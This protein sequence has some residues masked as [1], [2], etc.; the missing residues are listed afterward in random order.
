MEMLWDAN[1]RA[2]GAYDVPATS[3]VVLV[4]KDGKV[5]YGGVG[6]GQKL[7]EAIRKIIQ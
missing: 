3:Y 2:T 1:G 5:A 7:D 4:G 6:S